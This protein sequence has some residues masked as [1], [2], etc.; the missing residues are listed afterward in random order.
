MAL[1][2]PSQASLASAHFPG[3][4]LVR[5][6]SNLS[7]GTPENGPGSPT[8]QQSKPKPAQQQPPAFRPAPL[9]ALIVPP[10]P[11]VPLAP[12]YEHSLLPLIVLTYEGSV[13]SGIFHGHGTAK[14]VSGHT[15]TVRLSRVCFSG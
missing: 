12:M 4:S 10:P 14:F 5:S 3:S 13:R 8:F 1:N 2:L 6:S 7:S 11:V 15:Y 9:P